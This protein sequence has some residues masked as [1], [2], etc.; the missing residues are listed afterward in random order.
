M[1]FGTKKAGSVFQLK[2]QL[3]YLPIEVGEP[4]QKFRGE[5]LQR[6]AISGSGNISGENLKKKKKMNDVL[7]VGAQ[8]WRRKL[9]AIYF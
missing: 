3:E 9:R 5:M 1:R 6:F 7:K 8:S 2:V 4:N